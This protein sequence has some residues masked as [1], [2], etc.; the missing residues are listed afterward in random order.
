MAQAFI[1]FIAI[2][3]LA[4][5]NDGFSIQ[6]AGRKAQELFAASAETKHEIKEKKNPAAEI[7]VNV[8]NSG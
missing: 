4:F 3:I 8:K 6:D 7:Y 1:S 2:I 5:F